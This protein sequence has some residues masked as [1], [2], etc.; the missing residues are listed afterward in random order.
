M[1]PAAPTLKSSV[2]DWTLPVRLEG[3]LARGQDRGAVAHDELRFAS[4]VAALVKADH[5]GQAGIGHRSRRHHRIVDLD[6]VRGVFRAEAD[7]VNRDVT[8]A[9][10]GDRLGVDAARVVGAIGEEDDRADR[11]LLRFLGE[12]LE[13]VADAR[14]GR[15]RLQLLQVGDARQVAVETI[16]ARLKLLLDAGERAVL[17]RLDRLGLPRGPVFGDAPCCASRPPGRR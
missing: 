16:E 12:L 10:R 1:A 6:V 2:S 13:A 3:H 9:Q 7:R 15:G 11:Q 8:A 4:G 17:K 5:R 14:G